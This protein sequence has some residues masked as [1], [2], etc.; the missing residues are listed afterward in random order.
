MVCVGCRSGRVTTGRSVPVFTYLRGPMLG[1]AG[2]SPE[3]WRFCNARP[4]DAVPPDVVRA[5][6]LVLVAPG[7]AFRARPECIK[8]A[9][10][11]RFGEPDGVVNS[12]GLRSP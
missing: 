7:S 6:V 10:L 12:Q 1:H 9:W 3:L 4:P 8:R 5:S 2:I 11:R